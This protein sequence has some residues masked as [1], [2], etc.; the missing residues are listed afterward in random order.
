MAVKSTRCRRFVRRAFLSFPLKTM[1]DSRV[2]QGR[3]RT[4][5]FLGQSLVV[6]LAALTV[7][8]GLPRLAVRGAAAQ[9]NGQFSGERLYA[10]A[11][12]AETVE[13]QNRVLEKIERFREGQ[14]GTELN[15]YLI[16]LEAWLLHQRGEA[17]AKKAAEANR[18]GETDIGRRLDAKAM[19]DFD[20]AIRL[21]PD[22]WK[23]YHHRGVCYALMGEFERA[24]SD[25]SKTIELRPQYANAW[26]NRG[27][28]QYE[29]GR[30]DKAIDDYTQAI[31]REPEDAGYYTSRGHTHF[32][33]RQFQ[34]ALDD[35]NRAVS[36]DPENQEYLAN[37]GDAWRT[38]GQ[39]SKAADDFRQAIRLDKTFGRAYQ[40]AAWLMATCPDPQFRNA[41][42]AVQ[43]AQ[44]AIELD[45]ET[46]YIHL[47]TLAA[48]LANGGQ[49]EQARKVLLQAIESA[50][51]ENLEP[52][53]SRL[54][55]YRA[56]KPYRQP[57]HATAARPLDKPKRY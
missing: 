14:T 45:G 24:L 29:L 39:W 15:D 16:K 33:L 42:L 25:F 38:L 51:R 54:S 46:G 36:L 9:E 41:N 20:A 23:S 10:E 47:D 44:R 5:G 49:F 7:L 35:Y 32:Q 8:V 2:L 34:K 43:A 30:F 12:A 55:L 11:K 37:R 18:R 4:R 50:P 1:P 56:H 31:Q 17:H 52:L 21:A 6:S 27:E 57:A 28:I 3:R 40:A 53:H 19:E 26:F 22:R 13:Q 48:A